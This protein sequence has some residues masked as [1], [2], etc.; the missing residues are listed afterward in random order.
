MNYTY[1]VDAQGI[2]NVSHYLRMK[3]DVTLS[4]QSVYPHNYSPKDPKALELIRRIDDTK[5]VVR[6]NF[7]SA[8]G[9]GLINVDGNR[10][11]VE[12]NGVDTNIP[13][14]ANAIAKKV[15][16]MYAPNEPRKRIKAKD[17][18]E[19]IEKLNKRTN[20]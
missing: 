7:D 4:T 6:N 11:T 17:L 19:Y 3:F 12:I 15:Q 14:T 18:A 13:K 5:G 9:G 20:G 10:V 1:S 8:I 2:G 16:R